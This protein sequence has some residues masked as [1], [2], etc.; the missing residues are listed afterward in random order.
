[1]KIRDAQV[2]ALQFEKDELDSKLL[3]I[4]AKYYQVSTIFMACHI[5]NF[6]A[7]FYCGFSIGLPP[8]LHTPAHTRPHPTHTPG[9][10][11]ATET[12]I[13]V[14][15]RAPHGEGGEGESQL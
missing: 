11:G 7:H 14:G 3:E 5:S 8:H 10:R 2:E 1:M 13:R 12:S 4:N 15:G 6:C 9:E